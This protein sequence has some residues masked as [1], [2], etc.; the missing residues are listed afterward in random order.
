MRKVFNFILDGGYPFKL[1]LLADG[2]APPT[3]YGPQCNPGSLRH[4]PVPPG[5]DM[6]HRPRPFWKGKLDR[7]H[8][9]CK[10]NPLD[11]PHGGELENG[12][13]FK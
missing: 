13:P 8:Q 7:K 10:A 12:G 4:S 2:E 5:K 9:S 1:K 11:I 6:S 3:Q